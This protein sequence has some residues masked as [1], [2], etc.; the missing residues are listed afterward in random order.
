MGVIICGA[1]N[2]FQLTVPA[3]KTTMRLRL[4]CH[5]WQAN[6]NLPV[7]VSGGGGTYHD[8]GLAN[9]TA[10]ATGLYTLTYSATC[11]RPAP[12]DASLDVVSARAASCF[13]SAGGRGDLPAS[14]ADRR[15][16][17]DGGDRDDG[18]AAAAHG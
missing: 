10:G 6:G 13:Q 7:D 16:G 3:D 17:I 14:R 2:G 5:G 8:T 15:H 9:P 4:I 12:L 11:G 1:G 18:A